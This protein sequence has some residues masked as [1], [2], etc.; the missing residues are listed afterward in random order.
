MKFTWVQAKNGHLMIDLALLLIFFEAL[1]KVSAILNVTTF[2]WQ[3]AQGISQHFSD[4]LSIKT[5][6]SLS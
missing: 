4:V 2:M 1:R 6:T 3:P 5:D